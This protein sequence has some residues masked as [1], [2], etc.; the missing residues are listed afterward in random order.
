MFAAELAV[1]LLDASDGITKKPHMH[2][3][4]LGT[5]AKLVNEGLNVGIGCAGTNAVLYSSLHVSSERIENFY[6]YYRDKD[7]PLTGPKHH[8]NDPLRLY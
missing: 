6:R 4:V 3:P 2:D 8:D 5:Y 1:T 7:V